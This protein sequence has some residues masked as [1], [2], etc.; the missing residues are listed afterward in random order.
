MPSC[1]DLL[2]NPVLSRDGD[3][4]GSVLSSQISL[5]ETVK[6][7]KKKRT[8]LLLLGNTILGNASRT[9]PHPRKSWG[10]STVLV[11]VLD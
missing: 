11:V 3:S 4:V 8:G 7:W 5:I 6:V 1:E 10:R 9:S 2:C